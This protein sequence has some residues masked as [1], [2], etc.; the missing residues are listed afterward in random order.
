M[1]CT[2]DWIAIG[3]IIVSI[4]L[5][6]LLGFGKLLAFLTNKVFGKVTAVFVCYTFGGMFMSIGFVQEFLVWVASLW[7]TQ[8]NF[9]CNF[10]TKLHPEVLIYYIVLF[11]AVYWILKLLALLAKAVL[12]IKVKPL[13]IINKVGGALLLTFTAVLIWLV[14]FQ[15]IF[16]VGG[17]TSADFLQSLQHSLFALDKLFLYNPLLGLV[18]IVS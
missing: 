18:K 7:S 13:K 17:S 11:V 3:V 4:F 12:E 2:A 5:G 14:V 16:W 1:G 15:V 6:A 9:F 10:I 8:D